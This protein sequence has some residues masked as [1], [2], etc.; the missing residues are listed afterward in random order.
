M[1]VKSNVAPI[2]PMQA[3]AGEASQAVGETPLVAMR[4]ATAQIARPMLAS[5]TAC[6]FSLRSAIRPR[7]PSIGS[8][9]SIS[10]R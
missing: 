3:G 7:A 10:A 8:T 9:S 1:M 5:T 4:P 6:P 2:R